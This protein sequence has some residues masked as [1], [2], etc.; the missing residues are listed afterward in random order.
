MVNKGW[1]KVLLDAAETAGAGFVSPMFTG[2]GAPSLPPLAPGCTLMESCSVSFA[3]LLMRREMRVLTGTF[4]ENLDGGEWCLK[5]YVRRAASKGCR[6]C[7]TNRSMLMCDVE[8]VFGSSG[9]RLEMLQNSRSA[10]LA[11]WGVSRH[12]VVYFGKEVDASSLSNSIESILDGAR[13]GHRFT[14]L[15]HRRQHSDFRRKGWNALHAGIEL[16]CISILFPLRDLQRKLALLQTKSP[17]MLAVRGSD[18]IQFPLLETAI[19]LRELVS[20]I[21]NRTTCL[22][23]QCTEVPA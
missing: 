1:L 13:Q 5:E 17:D 7:I 21:A 11:A 2:A 3:V 6:T 14:L 22:T 19:P 15:L 16:Y 8:E 10:Y 4:D 9:R 23:T 12:Y 18:N 20:S